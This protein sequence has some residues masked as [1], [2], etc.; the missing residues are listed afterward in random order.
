LKASGSLP[1]ATPFK[2]FSKNGEPLAPPW[3]VQLIDGR[4]EARK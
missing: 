2:G 3:I 1:L 4:F